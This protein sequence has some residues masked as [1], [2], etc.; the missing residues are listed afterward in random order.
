MFDPFH[1]AVYF[2]VVSGPI[3]S[4]EAVGIVKLIQVNLHGGEALVFNPRK[5]LVRLR[6]QRIVHIRVAID[7]NF[8]AELSTEELIGRQSQ[9][10]PRQIPQSDLKAGKRCHI[11]AALRTCKNS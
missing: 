4:V 8:V 3:C 2:C 1:H 11:L 6:P 9:S 7:S 5:L 10:L